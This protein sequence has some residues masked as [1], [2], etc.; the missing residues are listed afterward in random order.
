MSPFQTLTLALALALSSGCF[1]S[2]DEY[3]Q[4]VEERDELAVELARANQ[5]HDILNRARYNIAQQQQQLQE[6]LTVNVRAAAPPPAIS[7][8]AASGGGS[9]Q[10]AATASSSSA[11]S[12]RTQAVGGRRYKPKPGD[13]LSTIAERHNTNVRTIISLNPFLSGRRNYMIYDTDELVLP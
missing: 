6:L 9:A 13:T 8:P 3:K 2:E 11:S 12:E 4:L 5:E 1:S 7:Q 10:S